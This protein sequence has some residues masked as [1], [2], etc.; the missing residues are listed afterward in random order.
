MQ[1]QSNIQSDAS[2][3]KKRSGIML[4]EGHNKSN[5]ISERAESQILDKIRCPN[6]GQYTGTESC[7]ENTE[8]TTSR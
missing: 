5:V 8:Q 4:W 7:P 1:L 3:K 6:A 2:T